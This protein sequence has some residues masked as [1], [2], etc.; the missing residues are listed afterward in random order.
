MVCHSPHL[1]ETMTTIQE[2][3]LRSLALDG[4]LIVVGAQT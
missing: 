3:V 2:T 1:T 4:G